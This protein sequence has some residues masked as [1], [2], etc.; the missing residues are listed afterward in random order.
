[1]S[2]AT[3]SRKRLSAHQRAYIEYVRTHPGCC[4]ADVDRAC[5]VNPSAGARWVYDGVK[6]LV[7]R[8]ILR[9]ATGPGGRVLLYVEDI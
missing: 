4:V 3:G 7:R 1:M 5:R 8:G 9:S 2:T 6:R